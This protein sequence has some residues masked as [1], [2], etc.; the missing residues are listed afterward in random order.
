MLIV[1]LGRSVE[2]IITDARRQFPNEEVTIVARDGD[3]LPVPEGYTVQSIS[4]FVP[5]EG[6]CYIVVAN[7]GTSVQLVTT[8]KKLVESNCTF[9]VW[10]MQRDSVTELWSVNK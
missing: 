10:D 6:V 2:G 9:S 5:K 8:I 3:K 4:S 1:F 7:G